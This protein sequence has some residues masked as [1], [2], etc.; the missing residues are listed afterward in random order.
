M[1]TGRERGRERARERERGRERER[2]R[3]RERE[4]GKERERERGK[5]RERE[6]DLEPQPLSVH[7]WAC[8]AIH[9]SQQFTC[10]IGCLSLK[11]PPPPDGW[12]DGG[13]TDGCIDRGIEG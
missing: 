6:R 8:S 11:L 7:Q 4:R 9:A 3:A 2:E 1:K 12:M 10:R 5:E 13:W